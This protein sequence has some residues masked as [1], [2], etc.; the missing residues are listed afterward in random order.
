[1]SI[2]HHEDQLEDEDVFWHH[3]ELQQLHVRYNDEDVG[4]AAIGQLTDQSS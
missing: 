4:A 1:M 2:L 3:E